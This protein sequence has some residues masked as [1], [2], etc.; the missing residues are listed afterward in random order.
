[1]AEERPEP[2][3]QSGPS[4]RFV[5]VAGGAAVLLVLLAVLTAVFWPEIQ[6]RYYR[7]HFRHGTPEEKSQALTWLIE[8]RLRNGMTQDQVEQVL[9][10]P[11]EKRFTKNANARIYFEEFGVMYVF[12]VGNSELHLPFDRSGRLKYALTIHEK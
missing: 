9:G 3:T 1:M 11:L 4:T 8:N 2:E 5:L 10:E 12:E 6:L 7:H